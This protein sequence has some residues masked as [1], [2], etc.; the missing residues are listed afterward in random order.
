MPRFYAQRRQLLPQFQVVLPHLRSA[1]YLAD[2][3]CIDD[4]A[5]GLIDDYARKALN[6]VAQGVERISDSRA[7]YTGANAMARPAAA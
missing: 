5:I 2:R 1:E 6:N 7:R 4:W 3:R